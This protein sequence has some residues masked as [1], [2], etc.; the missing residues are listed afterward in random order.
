L[1]FHQLLRAAKRKL[2]ENNI[3]TM[4]AQLLLLGYCQE[5][6]I[7]LYAEY[8]NEVD[9][10]LVE[11]FNAGVE[12][13][14]KNEPLA[15]IL[16][17]EPFLGHDIIVDRRVFIPRPETEELVAETL[18]LV[19]DKYSDHEEIIGLD[20]GTGSGAIPVT[21]MSEEKKIKMWAVDISEEAL[22]VAGANAEK[23]K[24]EVNY[25]LSDLFCNLTSGLLFDFIISNP[26]YIKDDELLD[27]SVKDFEPH[28]A[29]F[30]GKQ[31]LDFYEKI[32]IEADKWLKPSGFMAFEMGYD[33]AENLKELAKQ[34]YPNSDIEVKKDMNGKDRM[35][36]IIGK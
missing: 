31:G 32:M 22:V 12:R 33:Q 30:G 2:D 1:T 11:L 26:P 17:Y 20:I 10:E 18:M 3:Y 36:F 7:D 13:L 16:G 19:D 6:G 24:V 29:L 21:L 14:I 5:R 34:Y 15:Y 23:F 35:L 4:A 25:V 28:E 27:E 9:E 8:Q